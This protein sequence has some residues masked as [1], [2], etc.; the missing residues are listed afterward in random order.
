MARPAPRVE[1]LRLQWSQYRDLA[2]WRKRRDRRKRRLYWHLDFM[3]AVPT[4]YC[5]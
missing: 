5:R 3:R 1:Q 2:R 4:G